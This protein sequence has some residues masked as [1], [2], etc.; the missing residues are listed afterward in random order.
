MAVPYVGHVL[1][2]WTTKQTVTFVTKTIDPD[3]HKT[4][5]VETTAVYQVNR[6]PVPQQK[7]DQKQDGERNWKWWSFII[8]GMVYLSKDDRVTIAGVRY[9]IMNGSDWS[10]SGF[11]K[12]EAV[13]DYTSA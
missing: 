6:Q 7:I 4:V 1:K 8:R 2:G 5:E 12:F 13:E 10:Q 9:R 3:T 11:T